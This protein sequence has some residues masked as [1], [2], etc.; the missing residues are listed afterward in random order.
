MQTLLKYKL[1]LT[2]KHIVITYGYNFLVEKWVRKTSEKST[3]I[4]PIT[5]NE[6]ITIILEIQMDSVDAFTHYQRAFSLSF[7]LN[8]KKGTQ[9]SKSVAKEDSE[10]KK[11]ILSIPF[12]YFVD[13][14]TV[15]GCN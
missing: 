1:S 10:L 11:D 14:K 13:T 2:Q 12:W 5:S 6:T 4:T 3:K 15:T 8:N 9:C 7:L